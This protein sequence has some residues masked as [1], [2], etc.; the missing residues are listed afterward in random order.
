MSRSGDFQSVRAA[1]VARL[2]R[3]VADLEQLHAFRTRGWVGVMPRLDQWFDGTDPRSLSTVIN[4]CGQRD[5]S[6]CR[7]DLSDPMKRK[8]RSAMS[9]NAW[10]DLIKEVLWAA[11]TNEE[12]ARA[13]EKVRRTFAKLGVMGM[14]VVRT[15]SRTSWDRLLQL[16]FGVVGHHF[17]SPGRRQTT[18]AKDRDWKAAVEALK[19][20]EAVSRQDEVLEV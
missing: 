18:L 1:R 4:E 17:G 12:R 14:I 10:Q 7:L 15:N 6:L 13:V 3:A 2:K 5:I 19:K 11:P 8:V 20:V 16:R 9:K